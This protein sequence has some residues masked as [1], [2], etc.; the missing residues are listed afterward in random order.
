VTLVSSL[1]PRLHGRVPGHAQGAQR[2]GRP[3][4]SLGSPEAAPATTALAA[5]SASAAS[6]LPYLQRCWRLVRFTYSA[7]APLARKKR[8]RPA[9]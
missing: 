7:L 2:L 4:A 1:S 9:P 3:S 8:E 5:A 6:C